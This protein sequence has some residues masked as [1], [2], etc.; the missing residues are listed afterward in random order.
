MFIFS[1]GNNEDAM[2]VEDIESERDDFEAP[3][4]EAP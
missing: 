3:Q 1:G 4:N 2:M